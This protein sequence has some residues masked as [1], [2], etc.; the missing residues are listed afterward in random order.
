MLAIGSDHGGYELKEEIKKHLADIGVAYEDF[1]TDSEASCDYPLFAEK[2]CGAVQTGECERGILICGTGIGMSMCANKCRGIRA[3]LCGDC[4]SAEYARRH[5]D[6]NV[7]CMG[8]R[9]VGSGLA[10]KIVDTYLAAE[11]E[12]GRHA[13]RVAM[14]TELED[15]ACL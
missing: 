2:V 8:A 3:A 1:G 6:S 11:F 13:R 12:G 9:V 10:L 5:N 14:I 15:R 4:F 7:L